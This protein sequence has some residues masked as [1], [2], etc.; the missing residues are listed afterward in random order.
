MTRGMRLSAF[1]SV[2]L[3]VI[4]FHTPL[5]PQ[6]LAQQN[7]PAQFQLAI[8]TS[9]GT[10]IHTFIFSLD[11]KLAAS[12]DMS[13]SAKIWDLVTGEQLWSISSH[14]G[15]SFMAPLAFTSD[16]RY[17][18]IGTDQGGGLLVV[19][20][21]TGASRTFSTGLIGGVRSVQ[22]SHDGR[23]IACGGSKGSIVLIDIPHA[24]KVRSLLPVP[25]L[26][27]FPATSTRDQWVSALSFNQD[28]RLL[29]AGFANGAVL[30][31][32]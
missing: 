2:L 28:S 26:K 25:D 13:G 9:N 32:T 7:R 30:D 10:A 15:R 16:N 21:E 5:L 4:L 23:W 12:L 27:L 24:W 8:P 20:V 22:A 1:S 17:L 11:A 31:S 19:E 14:I 18:L 29:A 3:T 6:S